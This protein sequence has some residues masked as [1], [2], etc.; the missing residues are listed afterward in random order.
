MKNRRISILRFPILV[1]LALIGCC[2]GLTADR[3][4]APIDTALAQQAK[5]TAGD[6]AVSDIFGNSVSIDGD[7]AVVGAPN[8]D[9]DAGADAGSAYVFVRSG[10]SWVQQAKLTGSL[11][12]AGG[13]FG[14]AVG[15]SGDTIVV[16]APFAAN[17]SADL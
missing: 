11:S 13:A 10:S 6:A 2:V 8:D 17:E 4:A 15:I 3:S 12:P 9:T 16:G 1:A 14:A 7:T 5:L